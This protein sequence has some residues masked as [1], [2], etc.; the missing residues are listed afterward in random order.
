MEGMLETELDFACNLRVAKKKY[1]E[2]RCFKSI[3]HIKR[4]TS[5]INNYNM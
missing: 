5:L 4:E 2:E 3:G 1:I